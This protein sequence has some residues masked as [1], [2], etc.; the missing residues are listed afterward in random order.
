M[1]YSLDEQNKVIKSIL[2]RNMA[3]HS[4]SLRS[5]ALAMN[6]SDPVFTPASGVGGERKDGREGEIC[7]TK[8]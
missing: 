3:R 4:I 2:A 5:I 6:I 8:R 1:A 7:P